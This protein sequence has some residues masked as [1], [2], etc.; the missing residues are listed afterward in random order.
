MGGTRWDV[1]LSVVFRCLVILVL[2]IFV[3]ISICCIT[4]RRFQLPAPP[5]LPRRLSPPYSKYQKFPFSL[6][7]LLDLLL[8]FFPF[9]SLLLF[10]VFEQSLTCWDWVLFQIRP[11]FSPIYQ[12]CGFLFWVFSN[13]GV[14]SCQY[15]LFSSVLLLSAQL[16][17]AIYFL[18]YVLGKCN[19]SRVDSS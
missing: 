19:P 15:F 11:T 7:C 18:S 8:F 3:G 5:F 4:S 13:R 17:L 6:L 1:V 10:L 2:M 14:G 16:F 9:G 12:V